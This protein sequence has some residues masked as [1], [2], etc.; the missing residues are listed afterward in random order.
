MQKQEELEAMERQEQ[1]RRV[2]ED[3]ERS[4]EEWRAL[5]DY[6]TQSTDCLLMELQVAKDLAEK[7]KKALEEA[8]KK[9]RRSLLRQTVMQWNIIKTGDEASLGLV[10]RLAEC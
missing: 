8:K 3:A 5:Y 4:P 6:I 2:K 10:L 9:R 7:G 1:E